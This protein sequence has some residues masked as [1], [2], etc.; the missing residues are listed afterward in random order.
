M[1]YKKTTDEC[2][3]DSLDKDDVLV[4]KYPGFEDDKET[5]EDDIM[6]TVYLAGDILSEGARMRRAWE[7][8]QLRSIGATL[9]VPHEDKSINDKANAVQ[10]G[11]AERIVA[12]DT[13]GI[14][15]SDVIVIDAHENGKG[16]L[17][18][19]GQIKGMRDMAN[20]VGSIFDEYDDA[21][22]D[23]SIS[24]R[25]GEL[26]GD[27]ERAIESVLEKKIYA[28][29]TDIRRA[30]DKPQAGDRREYAPNQYVYGTVLELTDNHGFYTWDEIEEELKTDG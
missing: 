20:I 1:E 5:K 13:Q 24:F 19:L 23:D 30:N 10:E 26:I 8:N 11:L 22:A 9:H 17:V 12:N 6:G 27:V 4:A 29:N 7:A 21:L 25:L 16:T 28:H 2:L 3:Y 18:E 15:D 14:I